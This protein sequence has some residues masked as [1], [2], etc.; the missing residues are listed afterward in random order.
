MT[1][2]T[3]CQHQRVRSEMYYLVK[4]AV[5]F[6]LLLFRTTLL[7]EVGYELSALRLRSKIQLC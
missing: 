7:H 4:L 3:I 1:L 5:I 2:A 6:Q